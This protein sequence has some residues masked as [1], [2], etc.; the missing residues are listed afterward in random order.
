MN[1]G[2]MVIVFGLDEP[3]DYSCSQFYPCDLLTDS[4]DYD[5]LMQSDII[6]YA[7]G[8][9]VQAALNTPSSLMYNLNVTAPINITLQLKK[10]KYKGFYISFGSYMEV[11]KNDEEGRAFTEDEIVCSNLPVT[12]DYALSKRLYSRYMK[13]FVGEFKT[14]HFILPN[15]FSYDD[16]KPGTRLIPYILKYIKEYKDGLNPVSPSFSAGLQTREFILME[17]IFPIILKAVEDRIPSGIYN[18]GGGK[19]QSIRDL[20]ESIFV[21]YDVPCLDSYFGQVTRRD[22]DVRSLRLNAQKIRSVLG[23]LP[24]TTLEQVL[25]N[26][27]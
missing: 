8:A 1:L 17:D 21:F 2:H 14:L 18:M 5:I 24:T 9:G 10:R 25:F 15:M 12:N 27:I 16:F 23:I 19:F 13:D 3:K 4:L 26:Q 11:G 20:I 7:S 6:I 22:G